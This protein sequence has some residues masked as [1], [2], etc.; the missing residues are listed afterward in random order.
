MTCFDVLLNL[1]HDATKYT[2]FQD[3]YYDW[4]EQR[5]NEV[6]NEKGV[7]HI[8]MKCEHPK[9]DLIRALHRLYRF[10]YDT[11]C[12]AL[13]NFEDYCRQSGIENKVSVE[14]FGLSLAERY[15]KE[16][17]VPYMY[18]AANSTINFSK[19]IDFVSW[20]TLSSIFEVM[21]GNYTTQIK[22]ANS[23]MHIMVTIYD[24]FIA[25]EL[26]QTKSWAR[27]T[28]FNAFCEW[29]AEMYEDVM[30]EDKCVTFA[31]LSRITGG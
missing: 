12:V 9:A 25:P 28:I 27:G 7:A 4:Y 23:D 17:E 8:T 20:T 5:V 18:R 31:P 14:A 6:V 10:D 15:F 19:A 1:Q 16:H 3:I 24:N 11:I 29:C 21:Y 13:D 22:Y 30:V 2:E 26:L